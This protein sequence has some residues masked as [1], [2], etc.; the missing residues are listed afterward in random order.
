MLAC[1]SKALLLRE[2]EISFLVLCC[3]TSQGVK[4]A[5]CCSH[6]HEAL[7]NTV[8]DFRLLLG[9]VLTSRHT[10]LA[11]LFHRNITYQHEHNF[12]FLVACLFA[13]SAH[14]DVDKT[15]KEKCLTQ[16]HCGV[17]LAA[18]SPSSPGPEG[19]KQQQLMG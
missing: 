10:A 11:A 17:S 14:L 9:Q 7:H 18:R 1:L 12:L 5:G 4:E 16:I 15:L 8:V 13:S 19:E 3:T 6:P 2:K